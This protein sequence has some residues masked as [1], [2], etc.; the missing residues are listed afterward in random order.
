MMIFS[1]I[2]RP[3]REVSRVGEAPY[4]PSEVRYR[5]E[6]EPTF[7][8]FVYGPLTRG[9]LGVAERMKVIQAGSLHAYLAYVIALVV[10]LVVLLWWRG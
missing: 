9:V 3:T 5:A 6:I 7:E 10:S 1:A 8:R 4:F 2:Y